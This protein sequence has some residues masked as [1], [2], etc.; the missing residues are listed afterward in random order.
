MGKPTGGILRLDWERHAVSLSNSQLIAS[1]QPR[2]Y[3]LRPGKIP[4]VYMELAQVKTQNDALVFTQRW[5]YLARSLKYVWVAGVLNEAEDMRKCLTVW[6][7]EWDHGASS[8]RLPKWAREFDGMRG[9]QE[10]VE[11]SPQQW[12]QIRRR[13]P[14][15]SVGIAGTFLTLKVSTGL[16]ELAVNLVRGHPGTMWKSKMQPTKRHGHLW[17]RP[18]WWSLRFEI[19]DLLTFCYLELALDIVGGR[20]PAVCPY[21]GK[22]YVVRKP[23]VQNTCGANRCRKAAFERRGR[24]KRLA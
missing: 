1:G 16:A 9:L 20:Y 23:T 19:R 11:A 5:G 14:S 24:E 22:P 21:C 4:R 10:N 17:R 15:T 13:L 3:R 8:R 2:P 18:P 7:G 12:P 6:R